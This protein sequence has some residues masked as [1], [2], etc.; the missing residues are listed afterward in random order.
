ME[1]TMESWLTEVEIKLINLRPYTSSE[2][3]KEQMELLEELRCEM[4]EKK[5]YMDT[6]NQI[7]SNNPNLKL[8]TIE[9]GVQELNDRYNQV[10]FIICYV[11]KVII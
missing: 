4:K 10:S 11:P 6:L 5:S 2:D 9:G 8:L 1:K 7:F 3:E